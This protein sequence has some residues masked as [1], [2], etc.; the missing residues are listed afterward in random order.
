MQDP[1]SVSRSRDLSHDAYVTAGQWQ[2]WLIRSVVTRLAQNELTLSEMRF[3]CLFYFFPSSGDAG[4][5]SAARV[6][7]DTDVSVWT[8]ERTFWFLA[9]PFPPPP[10][11]VELTQHSGDTSVILSCVPAARAAIRLAWPQQGREAIRSSLLRPFCWHI[12]KG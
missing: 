6:E 10:G 9:T 4:G 8:R 5:L 2:A 11:P 12:F 7:A 3:F 1:R